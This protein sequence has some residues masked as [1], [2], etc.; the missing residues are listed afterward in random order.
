MI[1]A[2]PSA[3][4]QDFRVTDSQ[5]QWMNQKLG[6]AQESMQKVREA[7]TQKLVSDNTRSNVKTWRLRVEDIEGETKKDKQEEKSLNDTR[8]SLYPLIVKNGR[9]EYQPWCLTDMH[10]VMER[11]TT[12][13]QRGRQLA[14]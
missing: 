10:A 7:L 13:Y 2:T 8:I 4:I 9:D 11:I 12:C 3:P 1:K 5:K 6:S 14:S